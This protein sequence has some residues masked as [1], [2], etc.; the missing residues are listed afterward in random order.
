M[1]NGTSDTSYSTRDQTI[2]LCMVGTLGISKDGA[3]PELSV[4]YVP[5]RGDGEEV[6]VTAVAT[7]IVEGTALYHSFGSGWLYSFYETTIEGERELTWKL[8]GGK[9]SCIE[10]KVTTDGTISEHFSLLQPLVSAEAVGN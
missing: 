6:T 5:Q 9:L 3:I 7:P 4:T 8:S 10:L 1:A 2:R